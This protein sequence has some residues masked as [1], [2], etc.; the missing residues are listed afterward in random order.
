MCCLRV[1]VGLDG[2]VV[3]VA[4]AVINSVATELYPLICWWSRERDSE[5]CRPRQFNS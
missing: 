3:V 1:A 2:A 4:A 5:S